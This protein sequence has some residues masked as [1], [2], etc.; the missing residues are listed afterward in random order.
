MGQVISAFASSISDSDTDDQLKAQ[1]T[2]L[3]DLANLKV[4]L[5]QETL[6]GTGVDQSR[7][8]IDHIMSDHSEQRAEIAQDPTAIANEIK[9]VVGAFS[10]GDFVD[11]LTG[12]LSGALVSLIGRTNIGFS[13]VKD[14]L[15]CVSKFGAVMRVDYTFYTYKTRVTKIV[16]KTQSLTVMC[17]AISTVDTKQLTGNDINYLAGSLFP[18]DEVLFDKL[19]TMIIKAKAEDIAVMEPVTLPTVASSINWSKTLIPNSAAQLNALGHGFGRLLRRV[20]I[21]L[22]QSAVV[23]AALSA[24]ASTTTATVFAMLATTH[25]VADVVIGSAVTGVHL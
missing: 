25:L 17:W 6:K 9:G 11:G 22:G 24:P 13:Q 10:K 5:F 23:L 2:M 12:I 1:L 15:I 8:K 18:D 7:L 21:L 16:N 4:E 3:Q 19:K 14:Y 20:E